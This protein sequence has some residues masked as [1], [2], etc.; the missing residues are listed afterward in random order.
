MRS[1][2]AFGAFEPDGLP[3]SGRR[4]GT[5]SFYWAWFI[6]TTIIV[7]VVVTLVKLWILEVK[8]TVLGTPM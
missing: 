2:V 7:I 5:F 1:E 6:G 8:V 3:M 4:T